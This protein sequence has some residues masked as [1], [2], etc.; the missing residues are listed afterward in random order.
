MANIEEKI[1]YTEF[2][3]IVPSFNEAKRFPKVLEQLL[4][5]KELKE[6][7]LVDDGSDDETESIAKNFKSDHRFVYIRH[8]KNKGKGAALKTG[9]ARAKTEVVLFLDADLENITAQKIKKPPIQ[10]RD[11]LLQLLNIT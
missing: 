6:V 10:E 1:E 3:A 2:S 9:L 5:I 11:F 8:K 7:I 4:A